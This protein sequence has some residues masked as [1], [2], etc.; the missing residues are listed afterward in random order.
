MDEQIFEA[1]GYLEEA[2]KKG[3]LKSM[4]RYKAVHSLK[5][6]IDEL[7][8]DYQCCG[9]K[10]YWEWFTVSWFDNKYVDV[11]LPKVASK[12]KE[13]HF[14]TDS[15]PFSCCNPA[16]FGPCVH[17]N[18]AQHQE[19]TGRKTTLYEKGCSQALIEYFENVVLTPCGITVF[20]GFAIEWVVLIL[21]RYLQTSIDNAYKWGTPMGESPGWL[22]EY[23]PCR[24]FDENQPDMMPRKHVQD[25]DVEAGMGGDGGGGGFEDFAGG[26]GGGGG[27]DG[28]GKTDK[29][30]EKKGKGDNK[31]DKKGKEKKA[32]EKKEKGNK[33]K[34]AG[35]G[36]P[37][38]KKPKMKKPKMKKP[39]MKKR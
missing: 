2:F 22:M 27:E 24:C 30:D 21:T 32:K 28:D 31:K 17:H 4:M 7:Q 6:T 23:M 34:K 35:G 13:G 38:M 12:L 5:M 25:Q 36:K 9:S 16:S 29:R 18:V 37:K 8:M 39:K 3:L 14:Y 15:A 19:T 26:F 20:V 11:N 10:G 1:N 33:S